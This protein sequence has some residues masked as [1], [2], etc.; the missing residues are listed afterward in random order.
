MFSFTYQSTP[1]I[2]S[3][4]ILDL[5]HFSDFLSQF[6]SPSSGFSY[7]HVPALN[8]TSLYL[9]SFLIVSFYS[10][11]D[12]FSASSLFSLILLYLPFSVPARFPFTAL[13][14]PKPLLSFSAAHWT[15]L[16]TSI[17]ASLLVCVKCWFACKVH[18]K[19]EFFCSRTCVVLIFSSPLPAHAYN[20]RRKN[21]YQIPAVGRRL[22]CSKWN[23]ENSCIYNSP[24][25]SS[26]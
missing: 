3:S 15:L 7:T 12:L 5:Y 8:Q 25:A 18:L 16:H 21:I 9:L 14:V 22:S 19:T 24:C 10:F 6:I 23:I 17:V 1:F 26:I 4:S 13:Q 11:K 20:K 2:I